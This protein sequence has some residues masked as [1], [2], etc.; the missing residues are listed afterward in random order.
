MNDVANIPPPVRGLGLDLVPIE[1]IRLALRRDADAAYA[2]LTKAEVEALGERA[3]SAETLAGRVA[4]KEAVAKSLGC[5][6]DG[7][8]AWQD[9]IISVDDAGA[10]VAI[11]T[12]GAAIVAE[13]MR[14]RQILLS[15]THAGEY[16]AASACALT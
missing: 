3:S 9:V 1:T 6:F 15:I 5:G 11:L 10:L 8:V 7:E 2:W 12:G 4:A 13:Q 14:V 16:A